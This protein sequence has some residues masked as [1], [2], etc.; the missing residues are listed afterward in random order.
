MPALAIRTD[1]S[2]E[3]L[4]PLAKGER[5]ARVAR[6]LLAIA[7]AL[8]G[9]SREAAARSAGMDRQTLRDWVLRYNADGIEGLCDRW[10]DGRS[11]RRS[12]QQSSCPRH[13]APAQAPA[14]DA[15]TTHP[16]LSPTPSATAAPTSPCV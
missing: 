13:R 5:D 12:L 6:R 4:R 3:E 2:A 10:G 1:R 9:M 7:N 16:Q 8:S 14:S 15:P 11:S